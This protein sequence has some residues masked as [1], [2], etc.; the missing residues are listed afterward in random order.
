MFPRRWKLQRNVGII[1]QWPKKKIVWYLSS[2]FF[3]K[4]YFILYI[5]IVM[6][7][8]RSK[9]R[10]H[11]QIVGSQ[12]ERLIENPVFGRVMWDGEIIVNE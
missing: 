5:K 7:L 6:I 3:D 4:M 10:S 11:P 1:I 9:G 8:L 2:C 12:R